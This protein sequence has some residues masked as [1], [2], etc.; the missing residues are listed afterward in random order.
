[1]IDRIN[2]EYVLREEEDNDVKFRK[3]KLIALLLSFIVLL[4]LSGRTPF[5]I[6]AFWQFKY[7]LEVTK[8]T[9]PPEE[10]E[11]VARF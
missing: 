9:H 1:M 3:F 5:W 11:Y 7:W 8:A 4:M 2:D 6:A 10:K